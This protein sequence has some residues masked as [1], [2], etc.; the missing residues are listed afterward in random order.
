M[1]LRSGEEGSI[2]QE[3]AEALF[4]YLVDKKDTEAMETFYDHVF[5]LACPRFINRLPFK[6]SRHLHRNEHA[7]QSNLHVH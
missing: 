5:G 6:T 3:E 1:L 4:K 7:I 2:P